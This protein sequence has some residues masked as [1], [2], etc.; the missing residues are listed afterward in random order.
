MRGKERKRKKMWSFDW[1][2]YVSARERGYAEIVCNGDGEKRK[3]TVSVLWVLAHEREC[4]CVR[5]ECVCECVRVY[6]RE[7]ERVCPCVCHWCVFC[8]LEKKDLCNSWRS[9]S[10]R[11]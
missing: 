1:L 10:E 3:N 9:V 2:D 4:E 6:V 8:I 11:K 5:Y 7:R